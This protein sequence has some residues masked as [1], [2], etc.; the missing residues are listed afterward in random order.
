MKGDH[1]MKSLHKSAL[2]VALLAGPAQAGGN[3]FICS[4]DFGFIVGAC[5]LEQQVLAPRASWEGE[6]YEA[7]FSVRY[8]FPCAGHPPHI[9]VA[10]GDAYKEFALG[11]AD[12]TL[13][14]AGSQELRT[15]DPDPRLTL[16]LSYQPGCQLVVHAVSV[17]PSAAAVDRWVSEARQQARILELS[18]GLSLLASDFSSYRD[19]DTART[20]ELLDSVRQKA[21]A[22]EEQCL[23]GDESACSAELH[24]K[25]VRNAL[26]RKLGQTPNLPA[27]DELADEAASVTAYYLQLL[28][29]EAAIGERMARRF[30]H[31]RVA[32]E[33]TLDDAL[34]RVPQP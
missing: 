20:R 10:S 14:L 23:A 27:P 22:F 24:F 34:A 1:D 19:W 31:F 9:G 21:L 28:E 16:D 4:Q 2:L 33:T 15:H 6:P 26:Q 3:L 25:A 18:I 8:S 13:M 7:D 12:A 11:S 30:R 5:K 29:K 17:S 32:I